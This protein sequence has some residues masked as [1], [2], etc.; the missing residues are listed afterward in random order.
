MGES[1]M[2]PVLRVL[3]TAMLLLSGIQA[4]SAQ[5]YPTRPVRV[6]VGFPAGGPTMRSRES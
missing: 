1:A 6:V 3:L 5:Q 2:A 4:S